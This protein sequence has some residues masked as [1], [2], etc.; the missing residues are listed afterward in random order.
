MFLVQI[1]VIIIQNHLLDLVP[2][3]NKDVEKVLIL[4]MI[5][6]AVNVLFRIMIGVKHVR[7]VLKRGPPE[8]LYQGLKIGNV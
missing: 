1:L 3:L 6:F 4:P 2:D 8:I 7:N 5:G